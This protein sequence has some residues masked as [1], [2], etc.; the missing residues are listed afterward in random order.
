MSNRFYKLLGEYIKQIK[1]YPVRLHYILIVEHTKTKFNMEYRSIKILNEVD[2]EEKLY[3][4]CEK[5]EVYFP[6]EAEELTKK[7]LNHKKR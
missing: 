3:D 6:H 4:L 5:N 7:I 1:K 2:L